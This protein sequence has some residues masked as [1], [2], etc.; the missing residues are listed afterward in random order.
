MR[1]LKSIRWKRVLCCGKII[2]GYLYRLYKY[3]ELPCGPSKTNIFCINDNFLFKYSRLLWLKGRCLKPCNN[4]LAPIAAW[5]SLDSFV[6]SLLSSP[7]QYYYNIMLRNMLSISVCCICIFV[8][9]INLYQ[10]FLLYIYGNH[11]IV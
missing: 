7:Y 9:I 6:P 1:H 8:I 10:L 5:G 4:L 2:I 3:I 11:S